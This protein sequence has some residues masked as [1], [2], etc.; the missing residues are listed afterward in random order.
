MRRS[1]HSIQNSRA[2]IL[3]LASLLIL[4][5]S[6]CQNLRNLGSLSQQPSLAPDQPQYANPLA[7]PMIHHW[8]V[9]DFVSDE[10]DNYFKIAREER[11]ALH[12]GI[13][14][15][16][17]IETAPRLGSTVLEPW[18]RDSTPGF[19][20]LHSTL[21]TIRR[22]AKIRVIPTG[23]QY[24]LDVKV[25]KELEDLPQ[26]LGAGIGGRLIRHDIA[27]DIDRE[28]V[29]PNQQNNGWVPLGRDLSLEQ[30]ILH[31]LQ[32]RITNACQDR[33]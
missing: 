8:A 28:N 23:N 27:L 31:N 12:D 22:H 29:D 18:H 13:M 25:Y 26:P 32:A 19:E 9:M 17:W 21:Q 33:Q 24:L 1:S 3:G 14:T 2:L 5:G 10:I 6:G 11:I 4:A 16:G 7:V 30:T 15:E 20:K